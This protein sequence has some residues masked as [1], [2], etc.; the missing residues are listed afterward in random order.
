LRASR[1]AGTASA[2]AGK[3]GVAARRTAEAGVLQQCE[4]FLG[5]LLDRHNSRT[6]QD[7]T[8][9]LRDRI[10]L[11][12]ALQESLVELNQAVDL[13]AA[14]TD[15]RALCGPLIESLHLMLQT[16]VDAGR[17]PD[18]EDLA[19]LRLL[20]HDRSEMMD[21]LRRRLQGEAHGP[22]EQ[23]AVFSASALFE[24]CVWLLR[25]YVLLL[26]PGAAEAA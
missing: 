15:T 20:T 4:Q 26:E 8:M 19:L 16:L 25:R 24:R 18:A 9:V 13:P 21:A 7:R 1:T 14:A 17:S 6:V 23:Q 2:R 5:E 12:A 22:V 3:L 10:E 11:L